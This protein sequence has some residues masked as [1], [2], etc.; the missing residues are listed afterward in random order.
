MSL[1]EAARADPGEGLCKASPKRTLALLGAQASPGA[2]CG[3]TA[4][5]DVASPSSDV[6]LGAALKDV[7]HGLLNHALLK[8][9]VELLGHARVEGARGAADQAS[10]LAQ[11]AAKL[12]SCLLGST[13]HISQALAKAPRS[14]PSHAELL[15]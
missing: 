4:P 11:G 1:L 12:P 14:R 5:G 8:G 9:V 15:P 7:L 6:L 3:L 2:E 13:L 10:R